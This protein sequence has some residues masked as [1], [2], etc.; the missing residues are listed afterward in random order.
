MLAGIAAGREGARLHA[1]TSVADRASKVA[2]IVVA[3]AIATF[4]I[5]V[6]LGST[7]ER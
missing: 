1:P 5:S 6:A 4:A 3:I 7:R 2:L